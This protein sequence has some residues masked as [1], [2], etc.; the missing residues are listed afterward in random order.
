MQALVSVGHTRFNAQAF[1]G[2]GCFQNTSLLPR[3]PISRTFWEPCIVGTVAGPVP[4]V[5][6]VRLQQAP[7]QFYAL[8]EGEAASEC[9]A[10]G[11]DI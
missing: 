2:S 9:I 3:R 11:P 5:C 8:W 1:W 7:Y 4:D 10:D 6:L